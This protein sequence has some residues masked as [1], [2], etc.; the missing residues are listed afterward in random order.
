MLLTDHSACTSLLNASR[1]SAKLARWAM[2]IQE[3]DLEIRHRPGKTNLN[4]DALS[5]NPESVEASPIGGT[6]V[7]SVSGLG[8][9]G[10]SEETEP[11]AADDVFQQK[12]S[13]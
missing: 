13:R 9:N 2:I 12:N 10:Q 11:T 6:T 4:A 1:P 7:L 8:I 5:R 3:L